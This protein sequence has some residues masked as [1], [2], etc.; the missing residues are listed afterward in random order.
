MTAATRRQRAKQNALNAAGHRC[1]WCS[2]KVRD[3]GKSKR[4]IPHPKD[5]AT[6]DHV[7]PKGDSRRSML[8]YD[9][10]IITRIIA[11]HG[12]NNERGGLPYDEFL[13]RKRPEWA[14]GEGDGL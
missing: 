13:K 12:C 14:E 9:P 4:G 1:H 10:L 2:R 3:V 6:W 8:A 11:C 7:Y 5:A